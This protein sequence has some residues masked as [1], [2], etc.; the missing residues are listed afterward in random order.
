L[1][2]NGYITKEEL[3][4]LVCKKLN[5]IGVAESDYPINPFD[6]IKSEGIYLQETPF[7]NESIRGMLVNGP[8]ASGIIINSNRSEVSKRFTAMHE[9]SHYW[10]HPKQNKTVCFE[11]CIIVKE[12]LEWQANNATAY[13]LMP[14][15]LVK[16]LFAYCDG[17]IDQMCNFFKVGRDSMSYRIKELKL[18]SP[19]YYNCNTAK[20][21]NYKIA[22]ASYL[23]G[24]L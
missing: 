21:Y 8:N 23:Y 5:N 13:A 17:N 19:I 9:L 16:D 15:K 4:K 18:K 7:S 11:E 3:E 6:I 24:G 2:I 12:G 1:I 22:E 20:D 14:T 10:F